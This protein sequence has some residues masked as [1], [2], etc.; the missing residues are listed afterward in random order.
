MAELSKAVIVQLAMDICNGRDNAGKYTKEDG[1]ELRSMDVLRAELISANGGETKFSYKRAKRYPAVFEILEE[2]LV[3]NSIQGF[4]GNAFFEE[5][6]DFRDVSLGDAN[7]FYVPDNS[8]FT[9]DTTAEGIASTLR[10]RINIGKTERVST[11]LHTISCYED[12][13]RLLAGRIDIVQF[14]EKVRKSFEVEK[15][16]A[17]H[18]AFVGSV[19]K[20]PATFKETGSFVESKL[21]DIIAHVE[22]DTGMTAFILGTQKGLGKVTTAIVSEEAKSRHNNL[23][24]YGTFNGTNMI[25]IKQ[26]HTVGTYDFAVSDNV[27]YIMVGGEKPVKFVTEGDAIMEMNDVM[28]NA[29]RTIDIFAGERYGTAVVISD[30]FGAYT[31]S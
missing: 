20:I 14:I 17:M 21:L 15:L 29:D 31:I 10:Q 2:I 24:Y 8:L 30:N 3:L 4:E 16:N 12:V 26:S 1:T 9:V 18:T 5:M 28:K 7:D 25:R 19:S 27:I 11:T 22:A 13:N 6:V 23:G